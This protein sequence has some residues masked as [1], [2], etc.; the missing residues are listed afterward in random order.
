MGEGQAQEG[1]SAITTPSCADVLRHTRTDTHKPANLL[2][3]LPDSLC[4][5]HQWIQANSDQFGVDR[6]RRTA[7]GVVPHQR[8]QQR[9]K[10]DCSDSPTSE[11]TWLIGMS[12]V[13]R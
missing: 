2:R 8:W 12:V 6:A 10:V 9:V 3:Q 5:I 4:V 7:V 13:V 11:A 1:H